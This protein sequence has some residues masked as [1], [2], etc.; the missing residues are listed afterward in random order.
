M[1]KKK[2]SKLVLL[3]A[4]G[5]LTF[6]FMACSSDDDDDDKEEEKPETFT[7]YTWEV[8]ESLSKEIDIPA[9]TYTIIA[10]SKGTF[11][12]KNGETEVSSGTYKISGTTL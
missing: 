6:S 12:T 1:F 7:T 4:A 8:S 11:V 5:L 10:S 9:A 2:I 3:L